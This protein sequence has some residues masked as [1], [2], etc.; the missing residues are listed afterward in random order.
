MCGVNILVWIGKVEM[1]EDV[2]CN[3]RM[4]KVYGMIVRM[5]GLLI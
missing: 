1:N 4:G 5:V 2:I 3:V